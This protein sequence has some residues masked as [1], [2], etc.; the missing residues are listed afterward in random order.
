MCVCVCVC[1]RFFSSCGSQASVFIAAAIIPKSTN[2]YEVRQ[3]SKT[4]VRIDVSLIFLSNEQ[5]AAALLNLL[6]A[7]R[8]LLKWTL[9][10]R[11]SN[12]HHPIWSCCH[13]CCCSCYHFFF[14][15]EK[16]E[17]LHWIAAVQIKGQIEKWSVM[18]RGNSLSHTLML[19]NGL[20]RLAWT[21]SRFHTLKMLKY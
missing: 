15:A 6:R 2:S 7:K 10:E 19:H 9:S 5:T 21:R 20:P 4:R 16:K 3:T 17:I 13:C 12:I 18:A 8:T 14:F 11:G 1:A